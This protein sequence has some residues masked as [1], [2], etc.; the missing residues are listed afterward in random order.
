MKQDSTAIEGYFV[1]PST[2]NYFS[3]VWS[4]NRKARINPF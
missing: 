1:A 4:Y 3:Y 2:D